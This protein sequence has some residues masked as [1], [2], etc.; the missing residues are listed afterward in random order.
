MV[1]GMCGGT[2]KKAMLHDAGPLAA[3]EGLGWVHEFGRRLARE[4]GRT[5]AVTAMREG[6][7]VT[8]VRIGGLKDFVL[9]LLNMVAERHN[10]CLEVVLL[11]ETTNNFRYVDEGLSLLLLTVSSPA[12]TASQIPLLRSSWLE[13]GGQISLPICFVS[14]IK[15]SCSLEDLHSD[16]EQTAS[17]GCPP[18]S[19]TRRSRPTVLANSSE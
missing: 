13:L 3:C 5:S 6:A 10:G 12:K 8:L 2:E 15:G 7:R 1:H 9:M 4:T 17:T 18:A 14:T 19:S 11:G 16:R